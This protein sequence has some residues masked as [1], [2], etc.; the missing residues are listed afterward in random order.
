MVKTVTTEDGTEVELSDE[1]VSEIGK[2]A[3]DKFGEENPDIDKI[4]ELK[5]AR[6]EAEAKLAEAE[7]KLKVADT[8]GKNFA[9]LRKQKE[10]AE[11]EKS[12]AV[13][14]LGDELKRVEGLIVG[15]SRSEAIRKYAGDDEEMAKKV[16]HIYDTTLSGMPAGTDDEIA[17]RVKAA[18]RLAKPEV[19]TPT[20][21]SEGFGTGS[22]GRAPIVNDEDLSMAKSLLG[23]ETIKK[24]KSAVEEMRKRREANG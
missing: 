3:L 22:G 24:N 9:E 23:D 10:A 5:T 13:S 11:K 14:K 6:E 4:D 12:E 2:E 20:L 16:N 8:T 18:V 21:G 19:T 1:V 17:E 7:E 15:K